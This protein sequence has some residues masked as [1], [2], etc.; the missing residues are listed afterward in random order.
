ME[1]TIVIDQERVFLD[2]ILNY[3]I[4]VI[5]E[6]VHFWMVRTKKGYFYNEFISNEFVALAKQSAYNVRFSR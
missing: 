4:R 5:D 3:D 6:N 2:T 1:R